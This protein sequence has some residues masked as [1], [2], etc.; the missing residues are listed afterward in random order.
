MELETYKKISAIVDKHDDNAIEFMREISVELSSTLLL[1]GV[2]IP[3]LDRFTKALIGLVFDR[4]VIPA[5]LLCERKGLLKIDR[6]RGFVAVK[7]LAEA[8]KDG[9]LQKFVDTIN[10]L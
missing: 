2:K 3:L 10:R 8:E 5:M 9:S 1:S 6:K 7:K 4:V